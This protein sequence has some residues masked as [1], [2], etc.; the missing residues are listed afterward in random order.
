MRIHA[1]KVVKNLTLG[2][3]YRV[4]AIRLHYYWDNGEDRGSGESTTQVYL[5]WTEVDK[6]YW[7]PKLSSWDECL[8][9]VTYKWLCDGSP[10]YGRWYLGGYLEPEDESPSYLQSTIW[11]PPV[12]K[13]YK[14]MLDIRK[15]YGVPGL[16]LNLS[17]GVGRIVLP[18]YN[19]PYIEGEVLLRTHRWTLNRTLLY[20]ELAIVVYQLDIY[21]NGT[22]M[23]VR[24]KLVDWAN[25]T[26]VNGLVW[27]T[28]RNEETMEYTT[29]MKEATPY[30]EFD[31]PLPQKY[32]VRAY[33]SA[34]AV[35]ITYG[36]QKYA[37]NLLLRKEP[38]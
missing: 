34:Y 36:N 13:L 5:S 28:V 33:A 32:L 14:E 37:K 9:I 8:C 7:C 4:E 31:I 22:R 30:A 12:L 6:V 29:Y 18:H 21:D 2:E 19:P 27:I 11:T 23:R 15:Y 3:E 35:D 26:P 16:D 17:V 38:T 25:M 24:L 20:H 10:V 1:W